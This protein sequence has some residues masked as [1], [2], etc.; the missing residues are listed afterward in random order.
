MQAH[1]GL[2]ILVVTLATAHFLPL[3][4]SYHPNTILSLVF[5]G[6]AQRVYQ[7]D[8]TASYQILSGT[9]AF[10]LPCLT[11]VILCYSIA[12]FAY[13]PQWLG[14]LILYLCIETRVITRAKRISTLLKQEQKSTARQLLSSIV[15]RD[16]NKLSS[17]GIAKACIDST[18]LRTV[19]HYYL[20]ILFYILLGPIAALSYKLLLICDHA[21]RKELKPN[22]QFMI[23]LKH[24]IYAIEWLPLRAFVL[25]MATPLHGKKV[26]HYLK[27]YARYFYQKN[28]GWVL[29]LFAANLNV[30]LGGPCFYLGQ[31]FEKMRLGIERHPEPSDI[32]VLVNLLTR[33]QTFF[34]LVLMLFWLAYTLGIAFLTL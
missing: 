34:F 31:R 11:I 5:K 9:L 17:V 20:I 28:S 30:Q 1:Q 14:G 33:I 19:R 15:A 26:V 3:L 18:C 32:D 10:I 8:S 6:I 12:Q 23:P 25:L 29:S 27:R 7:S 13:Y 24:T 21:W 16:V 22:S 4:S 2:L